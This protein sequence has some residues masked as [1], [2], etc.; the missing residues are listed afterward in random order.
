[1]VRGD[2]MTLDNLEA[3]SKV[4]FNEVDKDKIID[5]NNVFINQELSKEERILDF[6]EKSENPYFLKCGDV[7]VKISFSNTELKI[8]ECIRRYLNQ[9]LDERL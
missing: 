4:G 5:I 8:D 9:C 7:F 3:L 2:L 6:L 1:M